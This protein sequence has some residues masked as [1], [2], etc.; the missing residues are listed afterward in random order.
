MRA[1][2]RAGRVRTA[3]AAAA[4]VVMA[5]WLTACGTANDNQQPEAGAP[6]NALV[7]YSGRNEALIKPILDR[8]ST[9]TGIPVQVRYPG[10]SST[11]AANIAEEGQASPADVALL[12]DAG[13]LG[14]LSGENLLAHLPQASLDK[15]APAY[16]GADGT[17][18]GISGR[19]R[20]LAYDPR[21][22]SDNE[23]P[24]SVMDLADPQWKGK[25][26]IAP[27]NASFESFVTAMRVIKGDEATK[28]WL[29]A[30]KSN[31]VK[32]F[33]KNTAILDA[34]NNGNVAVGL[35]N[36][37]YWY[38]KVAELGQ[39][40]V[41]AR[42]KYLPGDV[43][44]LIN[45]AGVGVLNSSD[46]KENAQRLV[47]YLLSTSAQEY[48]A[49]E[50]FE[51]PLVQGTPTQQGLTPIQQ[52]QGPQIDLARLSDLRT[53]QQLLTDVGLR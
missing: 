24:A 39:D 12:Q 5:A 11:V 32:T 18:V 35:I 17:W 49:Q 14:A 46:Q 27:T 19:A 8:F 42:I 13:S 51:Y 36:H 29:Q 37:Y 7:V 20:V 28:N 47:D 52:L 44:G 25:L 31:D 38:E 40:K 43:G 34:V 30:M 3:M 23:L 26:A 33:D 1:V 45:V 4:A 15:V 48:F 16:R 41:Q 21:Q 53:T 10:D 9:E 22:V 2:G 50:T 6:A